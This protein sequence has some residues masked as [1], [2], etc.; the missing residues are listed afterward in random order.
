MPWKTTV[1][2]AKEDL[3]AGKAPTTAAG[4]FVKEEIEHVRRGQHGARSA[5]QAIAIG[6]SKARRS[7]VPLPPP[8]EGQAAARTRRSAAVAYEV[9]QGRRKPASRSRKRGEAVTGALKRERRGSAS[10]AELS[11]QAKRAAAARRRR[12]R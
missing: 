9:G 1:K 5:K 12:K 10:H 11:R 4:E 7:G 2:R 6:L 8:R 3:R